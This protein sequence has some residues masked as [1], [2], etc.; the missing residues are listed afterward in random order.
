MDSSNS[1]KTLGDIIKGKKFVI[2]MYQRNYKWNTS[3]VIKLVDDILDYY[4]RS[5]KEISKSLGLLT[6]YKKNEKYYVID[7]QQRF[8]TLSILLSVLHTKSESNIDLEFERD[9]SDC[10]KRC[11]AITGA[12]PD[13][14][15]DVNRINRNKNAICNELN[16]YK[17]DAKEYGDI[18]KFVLEHV[19]MLCSIVNEQPVEEFM[20]LNAYKTAFSIS[21]HIRA[22]LI[23]LNSFYKEEMSKGE[24]SPILARCLSKK[25]YKTAVAILYNNI[26]E[27]LYDVPQKDEKGPY[28]SIY[29]LLKEPKEILD[30]DKEA[31]INII[32]R[33]ML[34]KEVQNY[35]SGEITENFA[36]WIRMLQKLAYV[37]KLLD[38][39]KN[40]LD[41]GEFHSF[42]QIDD[43][44]KM[45]GKSFVLEVFDGICRLDENWNSQI[46]AKEIQKYSNVD[47]VL[48]RCLN[49]NSKKLANRY[50][51]AF[52]YSN[53]N[54]ETIKKADNESG[55]KIKLSQM[56]M[57]EVVD[58]ISGCGRFVVDRYEREHREDLDTTITI[59]PVIDLED[60]ENVN[61]GGSLK[62]GEIEG[63]DLIKIGDLFNHNIKIPVIQRDYCMGARITGKNDFLDYLISGFEKNKGNEKKE[64][65]IASTILISISKDGS[66]Y[67]FDG[68]QRTF[69]L[70]N[71]LK[72]CNAGN[73]K[74]YSFIGRTEENANNTDNCGSPYS[75]QA[76]DNL[77][78]ILK[79]KIKE[80]VDKD[81]F[82]KY[83][84]EN[85]KLK[86]KIVESVSGAE[87]FFMDIN[88]GVA[89]EKY[90]IFK[91]MLCNRL[92]IL[93]GLEAMTAS[94]D[95][96]WLDFFYKYRRYYLRSKD[97]Q[98]D[99]RDIEELL[100][101]RF[102]EFVCRFVYQMNHLGAKYEDIYIKHGDWGFLKQDDSTYGKIIKDSAL[103]RPKSFDEIGSKGEMVTGLSYIDAL[104]VQDFKMIETV[105]NEITK[106]DNTS[107]D[108]IPGISLENKKIDTNSTGGYV[109]ICGLEQKGTKQDV[110]DNKGY[111]IMRF[112]W[113]LIDENRRIL[114][115]YYRYE[116]DESIIEKIYDHDQIMRDILLSIL[117][118]DIQGYVQEDVQGYVQG[119]VYPYQIKKGKEEKDNIIYCG[120]RHNAENER[121]KTTKIGKRVVKYNRIKE[122]PAYYF[123]EI[124]NVSGEIVRLR[125]LQDV[126]DLMEKSYVF[127]LVKDKVKNQIEY[128]DKT[129]SNIC[130]ANNFSDNV[131]CTNRTEAYC[132]TYIDRY[133]SQNK[134]D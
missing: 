100:E 47:S 53:I 36:Y 109:M 108:K 43:Y 125:Y 13:E 10:K 55:E 120:Y 113:S 93:D 50:L 38:E 83:I 46:L 124:N 111:Y 88:G 104:D 54:E 99:E 17:V 51:E 75:E 106:I 66:I 44:Q 21:D 130:L 19:I 132:I 18:A 6:L 25:T 116:N 15:T 5:K 69:T 94:I 92:A 60:R 48:I 133:I 95:N 87:Q 11:K 90:E 56:A 72:Y 102:I 23:S 67:I 114:K 128:E 74:S 39:L 34:D 22:N 45:T 129:N 40:E 86:V 84:K 52:V 30:P 20:N 27:K 8:T 16:K 115:K 105:L 2:P 101:I 97:I 77:N 81:N 91:A 85:V 96:E 4:N 71:I 107:N 57:D 33:G 24:Y 64:S 35:A 28:K 103:S 110:L 14:C 65:L 131:V 134:G 41:S 63:G 79:D 42:K 117:E 62:A 112:I 123:N 82:A 61:F 80:K 76:V 127:A 3:V 7:G 68:Q 89:L 32:F 122:I 78:R 126:A 12:C 29:D 59:P 119:D 121:N 58:E 37:N 9:K 98:K 49:Q 1:A 31:R 70:Y 26:Q 118:K 73:I